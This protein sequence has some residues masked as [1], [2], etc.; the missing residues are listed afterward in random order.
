MAAKTLLTLVGDQVEDHEAMV[1]F[2][3]LLMV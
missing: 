1:P 2:Q 3:A